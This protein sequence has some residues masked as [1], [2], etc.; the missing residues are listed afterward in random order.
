[1]G[2]DNTVVAGV[3][4]GGKRRLRQSVQ[5]KLRGH[6]PKLARDFTRVAVVQRKR[7]EAEAGMANA[8]VEIEVELLY[9]SVSM[10]LRPHTSRKPQE[11]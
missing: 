9:K 11:L 2:A 1:V 6:T 4:H 10:R 8:S 3:T 7:N 5:P